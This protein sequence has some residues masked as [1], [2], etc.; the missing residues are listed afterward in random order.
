KK[1]NLQS[2]EK[3]LDYVSSN[4]AETYHLIN[5][6]NIHVSSFFRDSFTFAILEHVIIPEIIQR[7]LSTNRKEIRL[8]SA[9]CAAGQE[10]YSLAILMNEKLNDY[11]GKLDFRIFAT[12][13]SEEILTQ[14][15]LG[16][17]R[18]RD[19]SNVS[20]SRLTRWFSKQD[21]NYF[22]DNVLKTKISFSKQNLLSQKIKSPPDSLY[23][24]FDIIFC[25]NVL[26][27]YKPEIRKE[28]LDRLNYS[29]SARGYLIVDKSEIEMIQFNDY[30]VAYPH[31]S[32]FHL[33]WI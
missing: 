2:I 28:I 20:F 4:Q 8:W 13:I 30:R 16:S 27:Y 22:I 15:N 21:S 19:V 3:Y 5:S 11:E 1:W 14:A 31:T 26:L 17:Y 24:D 18:E 7:K 10:A 12:D 23:G 32:I 29:L 25:S 6:S 9:G 33:D